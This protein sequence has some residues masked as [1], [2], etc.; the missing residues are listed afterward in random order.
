[1]REARGRPS[2]YRQWPE[3]S[4]VKKVNLQTIVRCIEIFYI[5]H[6]HI[7]PLKTSLYIHCIKSTGQLLMAFL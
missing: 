2:S 6:R 5:K 7:L 3:I 4:I 1:M